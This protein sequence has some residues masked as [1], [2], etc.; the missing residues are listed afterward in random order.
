MMEDTK[1]D[2][3][4]QIPFPWSVVV[5]IFDSVDEPA[6]RGPSSRYQS[7]TLI[8]ASRVRKSPLETVSV[9]PTAAHC[10]AA[11]LAMDE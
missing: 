1:V 11:S 3:A 7:A 8:L 10:W 9:I 4:E 2:G 5:H 6:D